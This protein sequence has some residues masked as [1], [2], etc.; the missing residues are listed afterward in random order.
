MAV[1]FFLITLF[2]IAVIVYIV[3][4]RRKDRSEGNNAAFVAS[5]MPWLDELIDKLDG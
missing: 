4:V 1:V 2:M 3:I 5:E